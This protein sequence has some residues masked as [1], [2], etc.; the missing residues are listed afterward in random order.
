VKLSCQG[1][2]ICYYVGAT[3]WSSLGG[4]IRKDP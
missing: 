1:G 3:G 2:P 4:I